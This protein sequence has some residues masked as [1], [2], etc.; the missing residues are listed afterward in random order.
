MCGSL[1]DMAMRSGHYFQ[2]LGKRTLIPWMEALEFGA[3][4]DRYV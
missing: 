4:E 1:K 3:D 2:L